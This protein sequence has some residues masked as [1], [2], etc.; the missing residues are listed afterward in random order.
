[1]YTPIASVVQT[2]LFNSEFYLY[3]AH[4]NPTSK[5]WIPQYITN[6]QPSSGRQCRISSHGYVKGQ[7]GPERRLMHK[8]CHSFVT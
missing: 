5:A 3:P 4:S 7:E 8:G 1:M 2:E 6:C